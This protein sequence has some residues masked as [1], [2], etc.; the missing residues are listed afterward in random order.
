[1][2][3]VVVAY[4]LF[5]LGWAIIAGCCGPVLFVIVWLSDNSAVVKMNTQ[6]FVYV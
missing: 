2:Q 5:L 4:S 3:G 6:D 1:M